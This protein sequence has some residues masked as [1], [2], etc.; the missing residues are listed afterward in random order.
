[1]EE[2]GP[3]IIHIKGQ[4][5]VVAAA[6]S[7]LPMNTEPVS[8]RAGELFVQEPEP[9]LDSF[10]L[11]YASLAKTQKNELHKNKQFAKTVNDKTS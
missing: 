9:S 10:P 4:D 2:Y 5:D 11:E 6:L 7:C 3:E 1:M 8:R